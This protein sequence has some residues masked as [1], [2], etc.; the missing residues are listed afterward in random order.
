MPAPSAPPIDD[1]VVALLVEDETDLRE[2]IE[3]LL[4]SLAT[5]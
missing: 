4:A 2:I 1:R 5:E 3:L